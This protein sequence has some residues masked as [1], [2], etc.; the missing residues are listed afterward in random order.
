MSQKVKKSLCYFCDNLTDNF[1]AILNGLR[2]GICQECE[3]KLGKEF[4]EDIKEEIISELKN[5]E[6]S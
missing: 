6:K 1:F 4:I 3:E 2:Y 5:T